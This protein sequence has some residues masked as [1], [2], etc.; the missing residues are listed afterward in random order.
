M[1][2]CPQVNL[3]RDPSFEQWIGDTP[4]L[5]GSTNVFRVGTELARTGTFAAG[6]GLDPTLPAAVFQTTRRLM[7]GF[8][9]RF[10]FWGRKLSPLPPNCDFTL[11]AQVSFFDSNQ[12]PIDTL[13][14][15]WSVD[16][17]PNTYRQFCL[18]ISS[19]QE[20][21]AYALVRIAMQ[22]TPGAQTPNNCQVIIDD[23][24]LQCI[25]NR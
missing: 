16:Q 15:S 4:L 21:V 9:Y 14:Q 18:D 3:L 8:H 11:E 5:W 23:A 6:L 12:N 1:L 20:D 19:V 7:Q 2:E 10:C 25:K 13:S 22:V 17:V 24:S